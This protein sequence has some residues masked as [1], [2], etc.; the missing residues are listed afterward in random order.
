MS[1]I[2]RALWTVRVG[3]L[4]GTTSASWPDLVDPQHWPLL[5]D[6]GPWGMWGVDLGANT[7]HSD[8]R[9]YFFFGDTAEKPGLPRNA[10]LVAWTDDRDVLHLRSSPRRTSAP[11]LDLLPAEPGGAARD[12]GDRS[13]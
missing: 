13:G 4:I 9:L 3:Q 5:V 1:A 11:R 12:R 7:E 8:G 2:P 10:D 6:S